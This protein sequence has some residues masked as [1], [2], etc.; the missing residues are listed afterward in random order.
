MGEQYHIDVDRALKSLINLLFQVERR[1]VSQLALAHER[2]FIHKGCSLHLSVNNPQSELTKLDKN[3]DN[4]MTVPTIK[5]QMLG[6]GKKY[7]DIN[8][9]K[10]GLSF[11]S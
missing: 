10:I 2:N 9:D 6:K 4:E 11:T 8:L 5:L 3:K 7:V 1:V